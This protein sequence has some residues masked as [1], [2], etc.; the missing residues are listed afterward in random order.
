MM[1]I[2]LKNRSVKS[3]KGLENIRTLFVRNVFYMLLFYLK[4][5]LCVLGFAKMSKVILNSS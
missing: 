4:L 3:K 2:A 5:V 1:S